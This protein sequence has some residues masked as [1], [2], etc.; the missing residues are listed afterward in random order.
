MHGHTNIKAIIFLYRI[1]NLALLP[2]MLCVLLKET[3]ELLSTPI[4]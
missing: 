4:A 2:D 3:S 1:N